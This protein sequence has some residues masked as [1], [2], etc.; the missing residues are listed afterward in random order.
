MAKFFSLIILL[1]IAGMNFLVI[2]FASLLAVG[3]DG[4]SDGIDT[5]RMVSWTFVTGFFLFALHR[6]NSNHPGVGVAI[7]ALAFA[8]PLLFVL[9]TVFVVGASLLGFAVG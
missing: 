8:L 3:G 2:S 4:S 1:L 9:S 7:L 6:W 5:V